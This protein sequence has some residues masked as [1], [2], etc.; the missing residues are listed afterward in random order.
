LKRLLVLLLCLFAGAAVQASSP[1]EIRASTLIGHERLVQSG[2]EV[3]NWLS[4]GR[5]YKEQRFSP[6]EQINADNIE[7]LGLAWHFDTDHN[8]GLESTPIVV[9]GVMFSTGNW[10]VVYANDA[11]TGDLIW[12]YDPGVDRSWGVYACCDVVNR[13]VAVWQSKVYVG[14]LDGYLVA[15]DAATGKELWRKLTIDKSR[16]YTI[17]GAP[18]VVKGKVI[19]GNGG[20]EYGVRGYV[21]AYE[22]ETGQRVWRFW[23]VPGHPEKTP[24]DAAME[25]ALKTW[26]PAFPWWENGGGGTVWDSIVYDHELD[27]LYIGVGNAGPWNRNLRNPAGLDNLFVSSIVALNPDTGAYLWHYQQVPNDGFDYTATQNMILADIEWQGEV[28]KVLMQ[29]PKNGFFFL[30]DRV[31]GGL[32]SAEPFARVNWASG[33]DEK[34]RPVETPEADYSAGRKFIRPSPIGAHNWQPMS[35]NPEQHLVFI[36]TI[37]SANEMEPLNTYQHEPGQWNLGMAPMTQPPGEAL[38]QEAMLRTVLGGYW[39]V[40]CWRGI[41]PARKRDGK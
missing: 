28:R 5:T 24:E 40:H 19:I 21:S 17:T 39:A 7:G 13:G 33:Y 20:A 11:R 3:S 10:S 22:A 25:T 29:A 30:I 27:Q 12:K 41:L 6:L 18:R 23:T 38:F 8:R 26:D 35:Y 37:D 32:I 2:Q 16:P 36:P 9:D 34:G 15:L 4:H 31:S 1:E 14:T